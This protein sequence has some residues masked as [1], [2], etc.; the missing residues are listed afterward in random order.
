[1]REE[2]SCRL[3][4]GIDRV[5]DGEVLVICRNLGRSEARDLR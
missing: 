2:G 4:V 3:F 1:M 5:R